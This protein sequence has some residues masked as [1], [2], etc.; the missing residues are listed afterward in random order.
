M[1]NCWVV[2]IFTSTTIAKLLSKG[3]MSN[4]LLTVR[5]F[6]FPCS[7]AKTKHHHIFLS[8]LVWLVENCYFN[9]HFLI[10]EVQH[11]FI[12][13]LATFYSMK[14]SLL[15]TI[16]YGFKESSVGKRPL[17]FLSNFFT[18]G[19]HCAFYSFL[20][21]SYKKVFQSFCITTL[22]FHLMFAF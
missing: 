14:F 6:Y 1:W 10:T 7:L 3:I 8:L 18:F 13:L 4:E 11:I 16:S 20:E 9:S 22:E 5:S 2:C 15:L 21:S 17:S 12:S 19:L